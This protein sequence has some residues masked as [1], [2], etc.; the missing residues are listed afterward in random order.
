MEE[1]IVNTSKNIDLT[2]LL[3]LTQAALKTI[4][5]DGAHPL[6][7]S[8]ILYLSQLIDSI[9]DSARSA[10]SNSAEVMVS[11]ATN[12]LNLASVILEPLKAA[13]WVGW[14]EDGV[15]LEMLFL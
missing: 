5:A 3:Q 4:K 1:L 14:T 9:A 11:I 2:S 8:D 10:G 6:T 7:P 13:Q 15:R 12:Y